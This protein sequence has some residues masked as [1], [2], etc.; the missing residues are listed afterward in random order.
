MPEN[1][2][3][4]SL[5]SFRS[6]LEFKL[7]DNG[8]ELKTPSSTHTCIFYPFFKRMG[9]LING[10]NLTGGEVLSKLVSEGEDVFVVSRAMQELFDLGLLNDDPGLDG[11]GSKKSTVTAK[12]S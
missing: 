2:P 3:A 11:I 9:V 4:D 10:G 7:L 1:I 12:A 5:L 6:D 8:Y